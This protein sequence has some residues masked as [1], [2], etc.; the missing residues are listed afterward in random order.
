VTYV[1]ARVLIASAFLG[2]GLEPLLGAVGILP[3][4]GTPSGLWMLFYGFQ[5]LAGIVLMLGWQATR[6]AIVMAALMAMEAFSG[7]DFWH[8]AGVEQHEHLMHFLKNLSVIGGLILVSWIAEQEA[9]G[10]RR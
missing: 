9:A 7:H 8:Y 10:M 6:V 1:V 5:A 2:F 3:H 4:R